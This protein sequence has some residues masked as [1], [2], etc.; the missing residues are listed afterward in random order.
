MQ[1]G[2]VTSFPGVGS[3]ELDR[4]DERGTKQRNVTVALDL[5]VFEVRNGVLLGRERLK[6]TGEHAVVAVRIDR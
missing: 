6:A 5:R 3:T 1:F 4:Y 2:V